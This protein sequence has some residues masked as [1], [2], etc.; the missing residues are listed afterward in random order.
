MV[1]LASPHA[2]ID[3][4]VKEL[5]SVTA[6]RFFSNPNQRS[7][8]LRESMAESLI[9][10]ALKKDSGQDWWIMQPQND[11]P[12]FILVSWKETP[13]T[14]DMALFELV[15]IPERCESFEDMMRII[16]GKMEKGYP[17]YY[18]LLIFINNKNSSR[19]VELLHRELPHNVPFRAIW[20]LYLLAKNGT[21]EISGIIV[22]RIRPL[23]GHSIQASFSED[24]VFRFGPL[25][26][27]M[28]SVDGNGKP[29]VR[30]KKT[31]A[32][33]LRKEM[34]K[35]LRDRKRF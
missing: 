34:M 26:S 21:N 5:S 30:F 22:N 9:A 24:G 35:T 11:P 20:T 16:K 17:A 14:I 15:E 12:D 33:S 7:K 2:L 18:H 3:D 19:W 31:F 23:P 8:K 10:L 6:E 25:P 29:L 28:E 27:F 1:L 4:I 13:L 32:D